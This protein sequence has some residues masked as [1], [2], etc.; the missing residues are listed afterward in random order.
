MTTDAAPS[1]YLPTCGRSG[2]SARYGQ[3]T[4]VL[5]RQNCRGQSGGA[6]LNGP[7]VTTGVGVGAV[8]TF[9]GE[10]FRPCPYNLAILSKPDQRN[11]TLSAH[12]PAPTGTSPA[13]VGFA[14]CK[15]QNRDGEGSLVVIGSLAE[16]VNAF[17]FQD[18]EFCLLGPG[19]MPQIPG[20]S[21]Q[22]RFAPTQFGLAAGCVGSLISWFSQPPRPGVATSKLDDDL[23]S[24]TGLVK[25]RSQT[26]QQIGGHTS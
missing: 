9:P 24:E 18:T 4:A 7:A 10:T 25:G 26:L 11:N 17:S 20:T 19:T 2:A 1:K 5:Q 8:S 14:S 21:S 23:V 13:R 15:P 22:A 12:S 3:A 16:I 6:R